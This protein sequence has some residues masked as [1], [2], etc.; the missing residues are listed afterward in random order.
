MKIIVSCSPNCPSYLFN[1]PPITKILCLMFYFL[2]E[3][4]CFKVSTD[5]RRLS[6]CHLAVTLLLMLEVI[7]S[8]CCISISVSSLMCLCQSEPA[9]LWGRP[10]AGGAGDGGPAAAA[11]PPAAAAPHWCGHWPVRNCLFISQKYGIIMRSET[12]HPLHSLI[13]NYGDI[14]LH[15]DLL[16]STI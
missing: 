14:C 15:M 11:Q 4:S 9:T 3:C 13:L 7:F 10:A 1:F 5:G 12:K 6:Y 16:S 2:T 8:Y